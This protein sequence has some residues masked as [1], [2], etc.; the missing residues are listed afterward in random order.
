MT[1]ERNPE[2]AD[3]WNSYLAARRTGFQVKTGADWTFASSVG[4]GE[5]G[6]GQGARRV[7]RRLGPARRQHRER[8]RER[9][10]SQDDKAP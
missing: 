1:I 4:R 9:K 5:T 7:G 3:S 8:D 6:R 2:S 10:G